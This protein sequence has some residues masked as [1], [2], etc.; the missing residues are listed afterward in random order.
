MQS[1]LVEKMEIR[2]KEV[3]SEVRLKWSLWQCSTLFLYQALAEME[4]L[5][6]SVQAQHQQIYIY[7]HLHMLNPFM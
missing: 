6:R 7:L 2:W 3:K 4:E 1:G 5:M